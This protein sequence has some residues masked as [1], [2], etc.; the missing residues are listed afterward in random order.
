MSAR[1]ILAALAL[2]GVLVSAPASAAVITQEYFEG[3]YDY[4]E[5]FANADG[6]E[7]RVEIYGNPFAPRAAPA[8]QAAFERATIAQMQAHK[9]PPRVTFVSRLSGEPRRPDYRFSLL[10][11]PSTAGA[12]LRLC[13]PL[14]P[15]DTV[16][17]RSGEVVVEIA[18]CRNEQTMS[19]LKA[20]F[21]ASSVNDPRFGTAFDQIF[22]ALLPKYNPIRG[23]DRFRRR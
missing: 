13:S 14:A 7:F 15:T 21:D 17:P 18:F 12:A 1:S 16:M 3:Y 6:K 22:A 4:Q 8:E 20:R 19:S 11:N 9:P 23:E 2:G 5:F 10:F